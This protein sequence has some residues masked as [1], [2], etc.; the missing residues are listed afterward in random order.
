MI[1][2]TVDRVAWC[3]CCGT[4]F[5]ELSLK[6]MKNPLFVAL[7]IVNLLT[8]PLRCLACETY[9]T[10]SAVS[11]CA[12]CECCEHC[13]E[14]SSS[15]PAPPLKSD[16]CGCKSCIC[17]GAVV[18]SR[19]ELPDPGPPLIWMLPIYLKIHLHFGVSEIAD[20]TDAMHAGQILS[21]RGARLAY[22]S[23]QI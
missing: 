15:T 17:E 5:W 9:A 14:S 3:S 11:C 1:V 20:P 6:R 2:P 18:A 10:S 12:T 13:D 8:C 19:A 7:L 21:G 16:E 23:W 4:R 22:Q